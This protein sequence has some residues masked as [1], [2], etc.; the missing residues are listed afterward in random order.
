MRN[1]SENSSRVNRTIAAVALLALL[2]AGTL[3]VFP[4]VWNHAP[5]N[6]SVADSREIPRRQSRSIQ[7]RPA[8]LRR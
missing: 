2:V 1:T 7:I 3:Y 8:K 4:R 5:K 6:S